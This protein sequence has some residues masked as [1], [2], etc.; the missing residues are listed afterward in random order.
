MLISLV[1]NDGFDLTENRNERSQISLVSSQPLASLQKL[2]LDL[3]YLTFDTTALYD[4]VDRDS[5]YIIKIE[6][7]SRTMSMQLFFDGDLISKV[8][9]KSTGYPS[10]WF[11]HNSEHAKASHSIF[12]LFKHVNSVQ[13]S[14]GTSPRWTH[15]CLYLR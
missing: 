8:G 14:S 5:R 10:I 6:Q 12:G 11:S 1:D 3:T 2:L 4:S 13:Q 7:R 9:F 15:D